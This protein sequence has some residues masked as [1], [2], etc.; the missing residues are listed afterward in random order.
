ML[1]STENSS[2][3]NNDFYGYYAIVLSIHKIDSTNNALLWWYEDIN[4]MTKMIELELEQLRRLRAYRFQ[5]A[6]FGTMEFCLFLTIQLTRYAVERMQHSLVLS[7]TFSLS[8]S[9]RLMK[10]LML[11]VHD[12][13]SNVS[14]SNHLL[15]DSNLTRSHTSFARYSTH[16]LIN[17]LDGSP[18]NTKPKEAKRYIEEIFYIHWLSTVKPHGQ[19]VRWE[20]IVA[21]RQP[22]AVALEKVNIPYDLRRAD[23]RCRQN[24]STYRK[25]WVAPN[26]AIC[27]GEWKMK[28][29]AAE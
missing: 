25:N 14:H 4:R 2:S 24:I 12:C 9:I 23:G 7:S 29:H 11:P 18:R 5:H 8:F 10:G 6:S 26:C 3:S 13:Y 17:S 27:C 1:N 22:F 20:A 21:F 19:M 16:R 28:T 15:F